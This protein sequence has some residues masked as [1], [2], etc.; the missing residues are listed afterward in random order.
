MLPSDQNKEA[1]EK[2]SN[3]KGFNEAVPPF[4]QQFTLYNYFAHTKSE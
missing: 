2:L 1:E 4:K 3:F